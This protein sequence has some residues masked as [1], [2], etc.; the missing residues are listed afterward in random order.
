MTKEVDY[1]AEP[2]HMDAVE[3]VEFVEVYPEEGKTAETGQA[4]LEAAAELEQRVEVVAWEDDHFR[5]PA[6]VADHAGLATGKPDTEEGTE[7]EAETGK[8][9]SEWLKADLQTEASERGL[10]TS[11]TNAELAERL[12]ADDAEKAGETQ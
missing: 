5:V 2:A 7:D 6:E 1:T 3:P 12:E 9:Y 4:L 11:G 10:P 8:P